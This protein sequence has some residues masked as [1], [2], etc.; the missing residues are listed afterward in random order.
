MLNKRWKPDTHDITFEIE[1]GR[2]SIVRCDKKYVG[3]NPIEVYEEVL[4]EHVSINERLA[5]DI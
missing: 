4:R 5:E 1:D 3:R 2:I